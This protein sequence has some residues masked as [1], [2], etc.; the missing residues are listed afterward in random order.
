MMNRFYW[1]LK[2]FILDWWLLRRFSA[3]LNILR[4]DKPC[5]IG[6]YAFS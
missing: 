4:L 6:R 2:F 1:M 5:N 3:Y